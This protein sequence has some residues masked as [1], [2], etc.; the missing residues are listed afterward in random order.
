MNVRADRVPRS[1]RR[2]AIRRRGRRATSRAVNKLLDIELAIMVRHYQL[3]SEEKLVAR[4]RQHPGRPAR[5]RCRRCRAGLAHEVR[6]PLNAA[7]LQLEL[8]ERRLRR[9]L[10]DDPT[11]ARADRARPAGDR[12]AH[13]AAQR[14]PRVRA[15]TRAPRPASTTSSAIVRHVVELERRSRRA[16]RRRARRS[17]S[18]APAP[19][20]RS[21]R[22]SSTRSC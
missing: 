10:G 6:N 13:R 16:A 11:P 12:A 15:P 3:D 14:L 17:P 2:A 8:L 1:H 4:E 21:T 5:P 9:Q 19:R 7:K 18:P 20:A 22:R